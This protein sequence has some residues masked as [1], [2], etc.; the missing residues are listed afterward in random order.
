MSGEAAKVN[1]EQNLTIGAVALRFLAD[2]SLREKE[3]GRHEIYKFVRWLGWDR[4]IAGTT[5]SEVARY[6]EQLS[7]ATDSAKAAASIRDFLS[8]IKKEGYVAN[9]LATQLK[10]KRG[11]P[12]PSASSRHNLPPVVSLTRQGYSEL[13]A[14][15]D[16]LKSRRVEVTDEMHRAAAD[17]DFRE[18][19]PLQAARE[20]RGYLEGRITEL[21][22]TLKSAIII[23]EKQ[24]DKYKIGIGDSVILRDLNSGEEVGYTIVSSREVDL[25]TG[26]I[27]SVSPLGKAIVGQAPGQTIEVET[28]A[29]KLRYQIKE[30]ASAKAK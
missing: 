20:E 28:P 27:S 15:L 4:P 7:A 12:K 21:E 8:Y 14:Q 11:K 1:S 9:N 24:P 26:K 5:A 22:E 23:E 6:A 25:R 17:K 18:N 29:G 19:A 2:L 13:A 10:V 30:H 3:R 16:A